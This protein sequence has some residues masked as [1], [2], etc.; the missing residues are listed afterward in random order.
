[1]CNVL[2]DLAQGKL[3]ESNVAYYRAVLSASATE[4]SGFSFKDMVDYQFGNTWIDVVRHVTL[5]MSRIEDH[6]GEPGLIPRAINIP[7]AL[8]EVQRQFGELQRLLLEH[9]QRVGPEVYQD[10]HL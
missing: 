2:E 3:G 8:K 6:A 1:M 9:S 4:L 10:Q 7:L 5:V